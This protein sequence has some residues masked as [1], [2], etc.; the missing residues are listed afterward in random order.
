MPP[1][2][3]EAPDWF[4]RALATP[5]T[6]R[7]VVVDGASIH[8]LLWSGDG[9][10]KPGIL[11]VHGFLAHARWWDFIA[12]FFAETFRVAAIDLSGMGDSGSRPTYVNEMW[13]REIAAVI[14]H[15]DF[16]PAI[17]IGHSFGGARSLGAAARFP[18][19]VSHVLIVDS[20]IHYHDLLDSYGRRSEDRGELGADLVKRV[21]S[22][23]ESARAHYR[24]TPPQEVLEPWTQKYIAHHSLRETED[25]WTW[26][27]DQ[28]LRAPRDLRD[29]RH[30]LP[31]IQCPVT[32]THAEHSR[33]CDRERAARI[34]RDLRF[35]VGPIEI[36]NARHHVMLDQPLALITC[37]RSA[38]AY[39]HGMSIA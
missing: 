30:W 25:G 4:R 11:F 21:Y 18:D 9:S 2:I 5:G 36:P 22:D 34:V 6:S 10:K 3:S 28:H 7:R 24:L 35:P 19:R 39:Q 13:E 1:N 14:E 33:T 17:V 38:L 31:G 20:Y 32:I 12:P 27:W 26:K 16:G 15:A 37:L 29:A 23:Y 8:Y